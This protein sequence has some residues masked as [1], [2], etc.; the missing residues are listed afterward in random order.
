MKKQLDNV[1]VDMETVSSQSKKTQEQQKLECKDVEEKDILVTLQDVNGRYQTMKQELEEKENEGPIFM[2][3]V[4]AFDVKMQLQQETM[5]EIE[6]KDAIRSSERN[7]KVQKAAVRLAQEE[8]RVLMFQEENNRLMNQV[9]EMLE[10]QQQQERDMQILMKENERLQLKMGELRQQL[11]RAQ[12]EQQDTEQMYFEVAS[13]LNHARRHLDELKQVTGHEDVGED[14]DRVRELKTQMANWEPEKAAS[15]EKWM[16]E[17]QQLTQ[18]IESL[19]SANEKANAELVNVAHIREQLLVDVGIDLTYESIKL[20]FDTKNNEIQMLTDQLSTADDFQE[21]VICEAISAGVAEAE[22]LRSQLKTLQTQYTFEASEK[23]ERDKTIEELRADLERVAEEHSSLLLA[24]E[25]E[26]RRA[27]EALAEIEQLRKQLKKEKIEKEQLSDDFFVIESKIEALVAVL[28]VEKRTFADVDTK[29]SD[30]SRLGILKK[31]LDYVQEQYV[32]AVKAN[33]R[34]DEAELLQKRIHRYEVENQLVSAKLEEC[35][36][37]LKANAEKFAVRGLGTS[38]D[39]EKKYALLGDD[40]GSVIS[41]GKTGESCNGDSP[42]LERELELTRAQLHA[43]EAE[44]A[45]C[46]S[47]NLRMIF[48]VAKTADSVS[49]LKKDHEVLLGTHREKSLELQT[50]IVQY[51]SM[52]SVNQTLASDLTSKSDDLQCCLEAFAMQREDFQ[53]I[54]ADLNIKAEQ[55]YN[56]IKRDM[57]DIKAENDVLEERMSELLAIADSRSEPDERQ[58]KNREVEE[59]RSSLVQAKVN[60]LEQ[61]QQLSALEKKLVDVSKLGSSTCTVNNVLDAE[62]REFEAALIEM[63]EMEKKLQVAYEAKQCLESALQERMEA[64]A[65]LEDRLSVAEDKIAELEQQL[66]QKVALIATIEEQLR[67]VEEERE[68]LADEYTKTK[69]KLERSRGKLEEKAIELETFKTTTNMLKDERTRLFN[70]IALLKD[71][72]AK[73]EVQKA[74][75]ADS[76][77]LANE[78]LED[79]LNELADKIAEIEAEKQ[80]LRARLED[81]VYQSEED[82]HQ[83]RERLY[84]LE[85]EKSGMDDDNLN[86]ERTIEDLKAKLGTLEEQK[87]KLEAANESSCHQLILLED[88]VEKATSEIATLSVEKHNLTD[89]QQSLEG[90]LSALHDEKA[91]REQTLEE[92]TLK[93][94]DEL[95]QMIVRVGTL[96]T[97]LTQSVAEKQ[98]LSIALTGLQ[99][100]F[101]TDKLA[102]E[103]VVAKLELQ[104]SENKAFENKIRVLKQMA[105]KALQSVQANHDKLSEAE[106]R[107]AVLVEE[108][109]TAGLLLHEK[110]LAN[111]ALA[112]QCESLQQ[113][114]NKLNSAYE[115]LERKQLEEADAAKETICSLTDAEAKLVESIESL[116]REMAEAESCIM[117][118]VEER[119]E[120]RK[121][122]TTKD[123][124][125]EM[126]TAQQGELDL[127]VEKLENELRI[128][129]GQHAT[130][131]KAAEEVICNLRK[132]NAQAETRVDDLNESLLEAG[133]SLQSIHQQLTESE[134]HVRAL[135]KERDVIRSFLTEKESTHEILSTLQEDLQKK[136]DVLELELKE[137]RETSSAELAAANDTIACLQMLEV[138]QAE[139]L[140]VVRQELAEAEGCVLVLVEERDAAKKMLSKR[141]LTIEVLGA[142]HGELQLKSQSM[143]TELDALRNKTAAEARAAEVYVQN[144]K[145]ELRCATESLK[146]AQEEVAA[147]ELRLA[148]LTAEFE[149]VGKTLSDFD[150]EHKTLNSQKKDLEECIEN[151]KAKIENLETD[152]A[153][154]LTSSEEAVHMLKTSEAELKELLELLQRELSDSAFRSQSLADECDC[155]RET[156]SKNEKIISYSTH[157]TEH[158]QQRTLSLENELQQ[159]QRQRESDTLTAEETIRSLHESELQTVATLEATRQELCETQA[160]AVSA[161]EEREAARK[162]LSELESHR[163][164]QSAEAES[165]QKRIQSLENVATLEATR[166]ELCETQARA[167]SAEEEREAARKA[168]SELES[169]R[170]AQSAE[171][172][173]LQKRI[174]SLESELQELRSQQATRQELCETQARAVS[175]EEEREAARKALSELESHREAQSAE[176]ES[177]QKRIQ[178]LESEL[179]EL[180]SSI[181]ATLEATRQELCETQARAVS[182][183]EEREAARKALSELESHREAQSAEAESLQKRIQSL[184]SELQEL[185]SQRESD[186]L[187]AEETIRSLHESGLQTVATLEATR[188]ELCET[189]ARAVSAEEERE[190]A[191]KALSE[192]ESHR[193]A[194]SAEA[195][196]LQ[197]RIQSLESEL[198]ELRSQR[199]SDTLTAEETI[200][201]LHESEL[202]TVATLEATRQELC[203]TQARAVSAEEEREAARKALSELE[204]HREAQS[205]EAESL[206]KRIQ[207]LESELQELRSQRESD[208]LTA[209]ET[210]RSLHESGLQIVATLEATR[211]ELCETQARAVSAEEEREAARKALSELESHRE[212]QSAEAESLQKRI[213]SLES[214]LQELRSQRESDTLTAE[215]TIRSL[216]E[217]GL[218]IVATL[219][220]TRQELC[221][222]QARAVSAE[223]E[224]EAARKALSE[225]ESHR[226]A[227]SAEAE[228]LQK[229]IQS[230]ESELQEL[231]SQRESDTLT[232]EETIRSLHE[233]ELQ[234]VATLE[235][236][237]QELCETQA[238]AVSAEEEREAAR[239]ALSEL[240]SHREAQSAEAESL[241][242]R[243]QSLESELQEL[244]SQRES[245]TLTAEETIRSLHESGLQIVATLEATRQELCETQARAVSAE[246]EREAARKA[247]S[248]LESHREAQSAEAESL[249]KRIQSLESELQELRSQRESDTLTAE[250]TIRSLH[251]SE[252]QTV[253]TLEATRQELCETQARAVSA[254][255]EREAARKALSELESHR[256]AQSAEAESLQKR[257]QSLESEL[258]ELRSQRESD[259]LTAEET[260]RSLHES[261]LQTVAT[262]EA[263]RQELCETQARAVSAEEEREAARK[264]LSELE[265]HREAQSAEAESLQK[266][267]QSLESELQELRSQR[268]SDTLTAEETIRSLHESELQTVATLEA[269]RQE[270][271]E[272]Q[273]RAVSAEEEREA[274]RKALSELESHRE[275]QSAEAESLQKRIQS[276]ESEL[277]ELRSQRESDTLTAEETIRSLHES[278]LQTVATLEATRQELCET[279][280]RAVSAEE[281]R[282]AARKALSELE[283]HREAQSAEAESLQK[284]IQSLESELQELRSQRESD[285]LTAEETIR[286]LHESELQTVA[287]LEA[288]RQELCEAQARAV[289]FESEYNSLVVVVKEKEGVLGMLRG[290]KFTLL[291]K[292]QS[293]E[294]RIAGLDYELEER[295]KEL[296]IGAQQIERLE[297]QVGQTQRQLGDQLRTS[298]A[299]SA[300]ELE[301]LKDQVASLSVA[302]GSA[303][304]ELSFLREQRVAEEES[305]AA[306]IA[307][308]DDVILTLKMKLEEVMGA[309]KRLKGHLKE[310]QD[311]LT[312]QSTSN[313]YLKTSNDELKA[314]YSAST[315]EL[316]ALKAEFAL[317]RAQ[318]VAMEE[319]L[320]QS[321]EK[322][323]QYETQI[324]DFKKRVV[325]YDDEVAQ[326]QKQQDMALH[327]QKEKLLM[328]F[329]ARDEA[330]QLKVVKLE[331]SLVVLTESVEQKEHEIQSMAERLRHI[332]QEQVKAGSDQEEKVR[333]YEAERMELVAQLSSASETIEKLSLATDASVSIERE[334]MSQ[335]A[336][337]ITQLEL[338]VKVQTEGANAARVALETYKKRAHIALKKALSE[339]KLNLK[340]AAESAMKLENEVLLA[341]GRIS[342]LKIELEEARRRMVEI[343][344]AGDILAQNTCKALEADKRSQEAVRQLEIDS[345]KAEVRQLKEA[346]DSEKVRLEFQMKQLTERNGALNNEIASLQ[347]E[348]RIQNTVAEEAVRAKEKEIYDLSKQLHAALAAVA[349]LA[350]NEAGGRHS[351]SPPPLSPIEKERRSTVSSTHSFGSE[352]NNSFFEEQ[353]NHHLAAAVEDLCPISLASKMT[354]PNC[355]E[356]HLTAPVDDDNDE[357]VSLKR[358][359]Q[360]MESKSIVFQKKY[361]DACALLEQAHRQN[362]HFGKHSAQDLNIEYLKNVVIKYI[363]SQV[364]SEKDQL[365]PVIAALLH[366]S[367]QEHHQVMVAHRKTSDESGGLFGG[368]FSLF[369]ASTMTTSVPKPLHYY[370]PS[371]STIGSDKI[372]ETAV[373]SK[374]KNGILASSNADPSDDENFVIPLNPFAV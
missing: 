275:A 30:H 243:I 316:D 10:N 103:E 293:L 286:S 206:Q 154:S 205:A 163:E 121:D 104:T 42:G 67:S 89:L 202:Q 84:I 227:Q 131:A 85:E 109:D 253:A 53:S 99:E 353:R 195:E 190:A 132:S 129:Q 37:A 82:I 363:A 272:T 137:L 96:Q 46:K 188:Q 256:E 354:G 14:V 216:H 12:Q 24:N 26:C 232:A 17:K 151:L 221:E 244:R 107:A 61:K 172:E 11:G 301:K 367:P 284:R 194:Q 326:V 156:L 123:L 271:C 361:E 102:H 22:A 212:S 86:L 287:T 60:F 54:I 219:E 350:S 213:Q 6:E 218:Q 108:R 152:H 359:L 334:T 328:A 63:I 145:E 165:L 159:M 217:S 371:S 233:S 247:L 235:A 327:D 69:S 79:Q 100:R 241:Q 220:A 170:E 260:I 117:V 28:Q 337:Q 81:T 65:E 87:E 365:V 62:R 248:E 158:Y 300:E 305:Y 288:T 210:I 72:I 110:E 182:A 228:S 348:V 192:L 80:D 47:E 180:R 310:L 201:S 161:E 345:L 336:K 25:Y 246:E 162:A 292:V 9:A 41:A 113:Q 311:R 314:L 349:S 140:A 240:E 183:E 40:A 184:E 329:A 112:T 32:S 83:L 347:D 238:R 257:I 344:S 7:E 225:L 346:L 164:S 64:K 169:H 90:N 312:Q 263:T 249:Q 23:L 237:R 189:Q 264:A 298:E 21:Q 362:E 296:S 58:E 308:K 261:E 185:R 325:A 92:A 208:T 55:E 254:E 268:E 319:E 278:E 297:S 160:R 8:A 181:V 15:A 283:S 252:L 168:L 341:K 258:Q 294:A 44:M 320:R 299:A 95:D 245:D 281:E 204:S 355:V 364:R 106:S 48:E 153:A 176:A 56:K 94:R 295:A 125:I 259:T 207:S 236:T 250:E 33:Q 330:A 35:E 57:E 73:S 267:I 356:Q 78:E 134:L 242:K 114:V 122:L 139:K 144:L 76:Q 68:K 343:E 166:Q 289:F 27:C 52:E 51:M 282:E 174:Q 276:L 116:K 372:S 265:S 128:L 335:L 43:V 119:D 370:K 302:S 36:I 351:S 339:N 133:R 193:E 13:N 124:K 309:Y 224:R 229:R 45:A 304:K 199:E 179:Q 317:F 142:E 141:E 147:S 71:K 187:T 323:A 2:S 19:T 191:R 262:L 105:E 177:L 111:K 150:T 234:T 307:R 136:M 93:L 88:R 285:T 255:E 318:P 98:E 231:R 215:E 115:I 97:Q 171:A 120:A 315:M 360:E 70:E 251:E 279:Q 146:L 196:S 34:Q 322:I 321:N 143:T 357:I 270:L 118:L 203:E 306:G 186:T 175:A 130:E 149:A 200:R 368:V 280:A 167:V 59:L 178:S 342:I 138:D 31:Y 77:E 16:L 369:G 274:A 313:A 340:K 198:Q 230:L 39:A 226:E 374:E 209:E 66:E 338:E 222:T 20:L 366:F 1:R 148:S 29:I 4:E 75:M 157:Q 214:E 173:S 269:T 239:K 50:M 324:E 38:F 127:A 291:G 266:R 49:R 5:S 126:M 18:Q 373:D 333:K 331:K 74:E 352:R 197:K 223:E 273:A 211:Q 155:L 332:E 303:I 101:Q 135:E 91:K 3:K 290:E 277:Q 358:L